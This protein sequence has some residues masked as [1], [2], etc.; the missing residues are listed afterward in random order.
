MA[1]ETPPPSF[2]PVRLKR[3]TPFQ[4]QLGCTALIALVLLGVAVFAWF[5]GKQPGE[6]SWVAYMVSA[7]FGLFGILV[8]WSFIRQVA[9]IGLGETIVEISTEP[10]QPG[11]TFRI[12]VIQPGPAKLKS[13]RANL[14]CME[15]RRYTVL[16]SK[17]N[18][19]E[20]RIQQRLISTENL[21]DEKHLNV[22]GGDVWHE[23]RDFSLPAD[24]PI[25]GTK[26]G[27]SI[28]WKIEV[29]GTGY[30]LA[31]FMHPFAVDVYHGQRP[32][33]EDAEDEDV[34]DGGP[35]GT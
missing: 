34:F 16:N 4:S 20:P 6:N 27:V 31:S 28:S 11:D 17:T 12:C 25:A 32:E 22:P 9:A 2:L 30:M 8:V 33:E 3:E 26:D 35:T 5:A 18:R 7:G 19:N 13:L 10:L 14:V 23:M 15:E 1:P 29:W 24:A 21:V